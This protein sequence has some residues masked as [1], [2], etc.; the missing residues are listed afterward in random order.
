MGQNRSQFPPQHQSNAVTDSH[1]VQNA[2]N[3]TLETNSKSNET[4]EGEG[5][6]QE[7]RRLPGRFS[8]IERSDS[9]SEEDDRL[10]Q[11]VDDDEEYHL[12]EP[13]D[14]ETQNEDS[15]NS[16]EDETNEQEAEPS[17]ESTSKEEKE[18]VKEEEDLSLLDEILGNDSDAEY[19]VDDLDDDLLGSGDEFDL[20]S[21]DKTQSKD[22]SPRSQSP[23]NPVQDSD[24]V[25]TTKQ[26]T[27]PLEK[28]SSAKM[29][30]LNEA[31]KKEEVGE[32]KTRQPI[33]APSPPAA[34][35]IR[36]KAPVD[37]DPAERRRRKFG[38][39]S[40]DKEDKQSKEEGV[41]GKDGKSQKMRSF[42]VMKK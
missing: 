10:D 23:K 8:R 3:P 12:E 2:E 25:A 40:P 30:T 28:S 22:K 39:T 17:T 15:Q 27:K 42:V 5:S 29:N 41:K 34:K 35:K 26:V 6:S 14:K 13:D 19:D 33:Q 9:E 24:K 11:Y 7:S 31:E 1:P 4:P 21:Q 32:K 36:L 38:I 18:P 16:F 37:E 20:Y